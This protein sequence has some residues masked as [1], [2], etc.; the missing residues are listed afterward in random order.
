M[1]INI[2]IE[3]SSYFTERIEIEIDR[4]IIN[5]AIETNQKKKTERLN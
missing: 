5:E 1:K 2:Q 4:N 3:A